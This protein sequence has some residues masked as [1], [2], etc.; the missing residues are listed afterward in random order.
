MPATTVPTPFFYR[1]MGAAALDVGIYEEVESDQSATTQAF[2]IVLLSSLAA[3]IGAGGAGGRLSAANVAYIGS[4]ALISWA[5]GALLIFE[6]G[7]RLMQRPRTRSD[8]NEL[9]RTIGFATTP[10]LL[11]AFGALPSSRIPIFAVSSLWIMAAMRWPFAWR[12]RC[13]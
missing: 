10:G 12:R 1:L 5:A 9:L 2:G 13:S 4:I 6:I 7:T 3:G 8:V 11:L